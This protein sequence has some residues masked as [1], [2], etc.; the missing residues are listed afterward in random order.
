[1]VPAHVRCATG[2]GRLPR[3]VQLRT[4]SARRQRLRL[5]HSA[6]WRS[7]TLQGLCARRR[8][9]H[10]RRRIRRAAC[11]LCTRGSNS[12]GSPHLGRD[13]QLLQSRHDHVPNSRSGPRLSGDPVRFH[14]VDHQAP[15]VEAAA[16]ATTHAAHERGEGGVVRGWRA[17]GEPGFSSSRANATV[18]RGWTRST[19]FGAAASAASRMEARRSLSAPRDSR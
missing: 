2:R 19:G 11:T 13:L 9:L 7:T 10:R 17:L 3:H 15:A 6:P 18:G 16:G 12:P 1:M 8:E 4:S 14:V 5:H